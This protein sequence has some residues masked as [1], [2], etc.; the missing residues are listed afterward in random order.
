MRSQKGRIYEVGRSSKRGLIVD[1]RIVLSLRRIFNLSV[2]GPTTLQTNRSP[3]LL[4]R[5]NTHLKY[6]KIIMRT[7]QNSAQKVER[8][9]RAGLQSA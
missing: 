4:G 3:N 2:F 9:W 6:P 1:R 8:Q 5:I 7:K